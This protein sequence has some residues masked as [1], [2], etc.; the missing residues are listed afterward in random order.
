MVRCVLAVGS[1][2]VWRGV[3]QA[4]IDGERELS[5]NCGNAPRDVCAISWCGVPCVGC[6]EDTLESEEEV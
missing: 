5:A 3:V 2:I 6:K 1:A 4:N